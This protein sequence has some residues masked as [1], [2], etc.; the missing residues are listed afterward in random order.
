[1]PR[2]SAAAIALREARA[3][4]RRVG[5]TAR[6][7]IGEVA[8]G[9]VLI[10]GIDRAEGFMAGIVS[11]ALPTFNRLARLQ[12]C[13]ESVRE[14]AG[15]PYELIVV[16]GGSTDG[17]REWIAEQGDL[18][19]ILEE[20][21]E[22]AVRAFNRA[23][24]AATGEFVTWLNDDARIMPG[25]LESALGMFD[26]PKVRDRLGMAAMYHEWH[27]DRNV[28]DRVERF[29]GTF[30]LCHVRGYPYANFG[31]LRRALLERVGFADEGFRFFGF[32]P[33]LSLRI[34]IEEGLLVLGCRGACVRHEEHH[35]ERKT[36]D[37]AIGD[38]DNRR[39]F[40]KWPQLPARGEYASPR[41][42]YMSQLYELGLISAEERDA[43]LPP[44]RCSSTEPVSA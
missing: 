26:L 8:T 31:V 10:G 43:P 14:N 21:R 35:D 4:R 28:L 5:R 32:D 17:S 24:R 40:E 36:G 1:M 38:E 42:A 11:I 44:A 33:D 6:L 25:A 22:G 37:L 3:I 9:A 27:S 16:D 23:F 18:R 34:Q 13:V 30:E 12:K 15:V 7:P 39:L 2:A 19:A 29:G 20:R 41:P